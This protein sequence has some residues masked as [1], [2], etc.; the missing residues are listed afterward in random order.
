MAGKKGIK[1]R[2]YTQQERGFLRAHIR[3]RSYAELAALF[4]SHFSPAITGE[5][6]KSFCA[7]NKLRNGQDTRFKSGH[8]TW[9]KGLHGVNGFS[10]TRFKKGNRP[11]TWKPVGSE[12]VN[13]EGLIEIKVAEPRTWRPKQRVIW[14]A[15]N[16]P[17]PSGHVVL[18]ADRNPR[19]FDLENLLA[20]PRKELAVLNKFNLIKTDTEL[21]RIGT[22]VAKLILAVSERRTKGQGAV[23]RHSGR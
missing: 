8:A 22:A 14:E 3:G 16:G 23:P 9:N 2:R 10:P 20:V 1:M 21:T 11:Q 17:L 4:N 18:F 7:N 19:N 5:Q 13:R 15:A 12:R 6:V